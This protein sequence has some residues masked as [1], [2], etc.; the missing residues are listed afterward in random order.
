M[1]QWR[2]PSY[3]YQTETKSLGDGVN[4]GVPPFDISE[5][6]LTYA[7]NLGS[8]DYPAI[9]T[10][11]GR[12][13]YSATM[14]SLSANASGFGERAN[15]QL[16]FTDGNTWKYWSTSLTSFV[17]L[18]TSLTAGAE[19]AFSDFVAGANRYT[20]MMNA[21]E[22]KYWDG[23][24]ASA[25]NLGDASTPKT[26]IFT[27]HKGR[28]YAAKGSVL[29]YSALNLIND[30][31]TPNDAGSISITQAKG[32]IIALVEYNDKVIA[33]TE[34]GMH[35]LFGTGPSNYELIDV[36]GEIGCYSRKSVVK[37]NK[38]LYWYWLD[39][40]YE[41]NGSSPVKISTPVDEYLKLIPYANREKVICGSVGDYLYVSVPYS[42][43][44]NDLVLKFDTRLGKWYVDTGSFDY[45]TKMGNVLYGL[46]STG[47]VVNMRD[48]SSKT[49]NGTAISYDLITK[50]FTNKFVSQNATLSDIW[51]LIS[52]QTNATINI[53]YSTSSTGIDASL[54][55]N[56]ART[57]D[58]D[59]SG[60][61]QQ[62]RIQVPTTDLQ[63]VPFYRLRVDG[64]GDVKI[65][66]MEKQFR[67]K[68]R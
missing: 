27:V 40:I 35:E 45:F 9:S 4:T 68:R 14:P 28:I 3:K 22:L 30:W 51:F 39:G 19:A 5:S 57:S 49:D 17:S 1:A 37:A 6:E 50:P 61:G 47:G 24:A 41:Y 16:H 10:R 29:Y 12:T 26:N 44:N 52:A 18:E 65:H 53:S 54:F 62:V 58:F 20:L 7:R 33:F 67:A 43:N 23:V 66:R 64:T 32:N 42:S 55:K 48:T 11:Y 34:Y 60:L 31:T 46:D 8:Q 38:N 13:F 15:T 63:N 36:E 25:S 56:I 2:A 59:F 21:Q